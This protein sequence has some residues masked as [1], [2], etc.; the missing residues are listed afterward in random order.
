MLQRLALAFIGTITVL[1]LVLL[2]LLCF[3][4]RYAPEPTP[5]STV[6]LDLIL[7]DDET[8]DDKEIVPHSHPN[9]S[10]A[11]LYQDQNDPF[12]ALRL[13]YSHPRLSSATGSLRNLGSSSGQE[14]KGMKSSQHLSRIKGLHL[15][16]QRYH[17]DRDEN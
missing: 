3:A 17:H 8:S 5:S 14:L 12:A 11:A 2:L 6:L 13:K 4:Y 1:I 16:Q 15:I 10:L 9:G 7:Q